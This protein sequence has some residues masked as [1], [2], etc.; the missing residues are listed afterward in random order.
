MKALKLYAYYM[1]FVSFFLFDHHGL[2]N[3][4]DLISCRMETQSIVK[5]SDKF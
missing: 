5:K 4:F 3:L 2:I 1:I